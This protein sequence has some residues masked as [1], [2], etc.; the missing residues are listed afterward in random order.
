LQTSEIGVGLHIQH[1][2]PVTLPVMLPILR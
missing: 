2:A 1:K